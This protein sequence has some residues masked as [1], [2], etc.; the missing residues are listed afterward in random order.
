M[1]GV[2][3]VVLCTLVEKCKQLCT[4]PKTQ[5]TYLSLFVFQVR[6]RS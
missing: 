2:V 5:F 6:W 3:A 4:T 1:F